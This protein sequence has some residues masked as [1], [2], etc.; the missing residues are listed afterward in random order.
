MHD[1]H[2]H[3]PSMAYLSLLSQELAHRLQD[4]DVFSATTILSTL[5][6]MLPGSTEIESRRIAVDVARSL[7]A[8]LFLHDFDRRGIAIDDQ[9][10]P[11][12][13]YTLSEA[14]DV[15]TG[16]ITSFL[17]CYSPACQLEGAPGRCYSDSCP[18]NISRLQLGVPPKV[19]APGFTLANQ[20][21][22]LLEGE[23]LYYDDLCL[24]ETA[25]AEPL[26][27]SDPPIFPP[28]SL[29]SFLSD[30]LLN[31]DDIRQ[32]SRSLLQAL[33][34]LRE[35][36]ADADLLGELVGQA[37][38]AWGPAYH[39]Y[40]T[41]FPLADQRLRAE[42]MANDAFRDVLERFHDHPRA[43]KRGFDTFHSRPAF[44]ALRYI[45][46]L[47]SI[48]ARCAADGAH[49]AS[50][51]AAV[52]T[53]RSQSA[54]ADREIERAKQVVALRDLNHAF[55]FRE[56]AL[57]VVQDL[58]LHEPR[59]SLLR[60]GPITWRIE[61]GDARPGFAFL[62]DH[63]LVLTKRPRADREGRQRY[64]I[65]RRP[66]PLALVR[67]ERPH[68]SATA[69]SSHGASRDSRAV[70]SRGDPP[71][72]LYSFTLYQVGRAMT[73][74]TFQLSTAD[75]RDAWFRT[76]S[77]ALAYREAACSTPLVPLSIIGIEEDVV[78]TLPLRF[79]TRDLLIAGGQGVSAAWTGQQCRLRRILQSS[80]VTQI[81]V[82]EDFLLVLA[83][84]VL[85]AYPINGV[86]PTRD[87]GLESSI[88]QAPQRLSGRGNAFCFCTGNVGKKAV[89]VCAMRDV[90]DTRITLLGLIPEHERASLQGAFS[91]WQQFI[92]SDAL[93]RMHVVHGRLAL[94]Y[95]HQ[96]DMVNLETMRAMTIP[97]FL[98]LAADEVLPLVH[99]CEEG[100]VLS[101]VHVKDDRYLLVF[102]H[103][104]FLV[105]TLGYPVGGPLF[106]WEFRP[107]Q[108]FVKDSRV[109]G[110]SRTRVEVRSLYTG[111]L[112]QMMCGLDF[113]LTYDG[114]IL[115]GASEGP[116]HLCKRMS[117]SPA[118][119]ELVVL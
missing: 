60:S 44:R 27:H 109:Y 32:H 35:R 97:D 108:A 96:I 68:G 75:A 116:V 69:A 17:P 99:L 45:L 70:P 103:M 4:Q 83:D 29:S 56:D 30:V 87:N 113:R 47:D 110:V 91:V 117:Q 80:R 115:T 11:Q 19:Y 93:L 46:L 118:M 71:A 114:S 112:L 40:M 107:R 78:A 31:M 38:L 57:V 111:E 39:H 90:R 16:L 84:G 23:Q 12:V 2:S 26:R 61:G 18:A 6:E 1:E 77:E 55:L 10:P 63:Y 21:N 49:S 85:I 64:I 102:D 51:E 20:I 8:Q 7:Q 81:Q 105:N 94:H 15:P 62:F 13:L 34:D 36:G 98:P 53:L 42:M 65:K 89:V 9:T 67:I 5:Q 101:F 14:S 43:R 100:T 54:E 106:Q 86:L 59:R 28:E 74:I 76:L 25:F 95:R 119:L 48:L 88:G 37:A 50:L 41:K 52:A 66:I 24:I 79:G 73:A 72:D 104:A 82:W 92:V 58:N 3:R 22:E 33:R